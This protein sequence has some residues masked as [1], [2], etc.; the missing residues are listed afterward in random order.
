MIVFLIV[1]GIMAYVPIGGELGEL[2]PIVFRPLFFLH[3]I[4]MALMIVIVNFEDI[5]CKLK[6]KKEK[7]KKN[8]CNNCK[9]YIEYAKNSN[10]KISLDKK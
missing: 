4:V 2:W 10:N 6:E 5:A 8:S 1:M 3:L 9:Y 7:S